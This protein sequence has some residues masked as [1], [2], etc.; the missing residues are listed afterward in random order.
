MAKSQRAVESRDKWKKLI[1]KSSVVPQRF[2]RLR[3]GEDEGEGKGKGHVT[4]ISVL[5]GTS[6]VCNE[7]NFSGS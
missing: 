1:V 3:I 7:V 2:S 4:P 6:N 5:I